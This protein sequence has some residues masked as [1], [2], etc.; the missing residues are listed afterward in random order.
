MRRAV[1]AFALVFA[2]SAYAQESVET[3]DASHVKVGQRYA[4]K[5][6][7]GN[8][9]TWEITAKTDEEITYR[10]QLFVAGK[11]LEASTQT[12]AFPQTRQFPRPP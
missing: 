2:L 4:W 6:A 11:E 5:L 3:M 9:S 8:R 10:I 7:A 12:H 1:L